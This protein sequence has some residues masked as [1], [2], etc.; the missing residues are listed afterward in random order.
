MNVKI[1]TK[2][3]V[4]YLATISLIFAVQSY[5]MYFDYIPK[6]LAP[7][8][9]DE[10]L[11]AHLERILYA[12]ARFGRTWFFVAVASVIGLAIG[13]HIRAKLDQRKQSKEQPPSAT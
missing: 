2:W 13:D 8:A 11:H 9:G 1:K 5:E 6:A 10:A 7:F 3:L 4:V 12:V